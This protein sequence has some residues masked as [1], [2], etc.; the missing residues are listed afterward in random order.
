MPLTPLKYVRVVTPDATSKSPNT[1]VPKIVA[2]PVTARSPVSAELPK[3][4]RL[5]LTPT[6]PMSPTWCVALAESSRTPDACETPD[7]CAIVSGPVPP[8]I[9][10]SP[11]LTAPYAAPGPPALELGLN[12]MVRVPS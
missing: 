4:N 9:R 5:P 1:R 7:A 2:L 8:M 3:T 12:V 10:V 6:L 11:T